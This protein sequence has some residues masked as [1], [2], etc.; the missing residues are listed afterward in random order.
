[1][2]AGLPIA[3]LIVITP[4][5]QRE[6]GDANGAAGLL[7]TVAAIEFLGPVQ[8]VTLEKAS[9][10][11]VEVVAIFCVKL[12]GATLCVSSGVPPVGVLY[13]RISVPAGLPKVAVIV[14]E[15][16]PQRCTLPARGKPGS[17]LIVATTGVRVELLQPENSCTKLSKK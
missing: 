6:T 13:K 17:E 3:A 11:K 1:V 5:P 8:P 9:K 7:L 10:K 14:T 4:E 15:P 12:K 16:G 2:P